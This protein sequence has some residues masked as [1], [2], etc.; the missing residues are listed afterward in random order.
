[1]NDTDQATMNQTATVTVA[2]ARLTNMLEVLSSMAV[3]DIDAAKLRELLPGERDDELGHVERT[4]SMLALDLTEVLRANETYVTEIEQTAAD[5]EEKLRTIERQQ[6][7]IA[8][9]STPVVEIWDDILTLPIVGLVDTRRS[10]DMT[11]RLLHA[12]VERQAKCVIIDIT[13]VDMVDTATADHFVKMIRA[14]SML[15]AYCVVSGI[16]PDVAQTLTRIGVE[17]DG[18]RTLRSLKDALRHC[19]AHLRSL[20]VVTKSNTTSWSLDDRKR[21]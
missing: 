2:R 1:M 20:G 5:L 11:E 10:V 13:G 14:S 21:G 7:A 12:I 4:L 8:E 3:G 17:L 18:V 19:F 16:S 15:G 9:L 6:M